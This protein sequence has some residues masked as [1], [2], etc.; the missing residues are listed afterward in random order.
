MIKL[1]N[2]TKTYIMGANE[3]QAL[4]GISFDIKQGEVVAI[5]G[6]SGCGKTTTM[7]IL[8]LLDHPTSGHYYLEGEESTHLSKNELAY[9]RNKKIGFVFQSFFLL[10]KLNAMQNVGLP[11]FY[12]N[13]DPKVIREKSMRMLEKVEVAEYARHKPNEL[14]GGQQQRVAI[15]RALVQEPSIILADEPTGALDSKT[16]ELILK[17]LLVHRG[18]TTVLIITHDEEVANQCPR[19]ITIRDGLVTGDTGDSR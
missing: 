19:I 18:E 6:P 14:S 15:A 12:A 1:E 5:M 2:V 13:V 11:L 9:V 16:S 8:G 3:F 7:N 10:P 4:K 17:L